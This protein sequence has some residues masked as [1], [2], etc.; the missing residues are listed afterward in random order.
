MFPDFLAARGPW[1]PFLFF[2]PFPSFLFFFFFFF[3]LALPPSFPGRDGQAPDPPHLPVRAL[4]ELCG[5]PPVAT[6]GCADD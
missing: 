5:R 6:Q 1:A 4:P 3:F 2:S